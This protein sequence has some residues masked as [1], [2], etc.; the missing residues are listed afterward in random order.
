MP[1]IATPHLSIFSDIAR[2]N[3]WEVLLF[4]SA[5]AFELAEAQRAEQRGS[6]LYPE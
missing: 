2:G 4:A 6:R 5:K 1:H 3:G